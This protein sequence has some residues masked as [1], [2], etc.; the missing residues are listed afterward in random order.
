MFLRPSNFQPFNLST[1]QPLVLAAATFLAPINSRA[2]DAAPAAPVTAPAAL[3][4]R[5]FVKMI[6]KDSAGVIVIKDW[7]KL[8]KIDDRSPIGKLI[9]NPAIEH[10]ALGFLTKL[11]PSPADI[12]KATGLDEA[13]ALR[14]FKGKATFSFRIVD[15]EE[16][17]PVTAAVDDAGATAKIEVHPDLQPLMFL[18]FGGNPAEHEKIMKGLKQLAQDRGTL[19]DY[20]S[21][22][23]EGALMTTVTTKDKSGKEETFCEALVDG[24]IVIA[25]NKE[26]LR[27]G[28]KA[29]RAGV[30]SDNFA[31]TPEYLQA[32]AEMGSQDGYAIFN[33]EAVGLKL[34]GFIETTMREQVAKN[35]QA[36]MFLD[37]KT[38]MD[39]LNLENF[40]L[41]YG[42]FKL[43]EKR[44]VL[45][46]GLTWKDKVGLASLVQFGPSPVA[47]PDFVTTEFK[48]ASVSTMDISKTWDALRT[49][50]QKISPQ[51]WTMATGMMAATQPEL[52]PALEKIRDDLIL[53]LEPEVIDLT[54][55]PNRH[56]DDNTQP[57]KIMIFK[58]KNPDGVTKAINTA[59][60]LAGK[61]KAVPEPVKRDY[62]GST[63]F[64][65]KG[66]NSPL[67]VSVDIADG[68]EDADAIKDATAAKKPEKGEVS[69]AIVGDRFIVAVGEAGF[70]ETVIANI[71]TPGRPLSK[72]G[73]FDEISA[74]SGIPAD[75]SYSDLA[76]SLRAAINEQIKN[77]DMMAKFRSK[78]KPEGEADKDD[79]AD[80]DDPFAKMFSKEN[81]LKQR[82]ALKDM[83]FHYASKTFASETGI[84]MKALIVEDKE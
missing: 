40:R 14:L 12:E 8:V 31:S 20:A 44:A 26:L 10:S 45:N 35:P 53:N 81:L 6:A 54:G 78:N 16:K 48:G 84:H 83:H 71:K 56:P 37:P 50:L 74:V 64:T 75:L 65:Y 15:K 21:E 32:A 3:P 68:E 7:G 43:E 33:L 66:I 80:Q 77:A 46:W 19:F 27:D 13:A 61:N 62:L 52:M 47:M 70:I 69:Y 57:G 73:V 29:L 23:F 82:D 34:R 24:A 72:S 55:F 67:G 4:E 1:F 17:A 51:G 59:L 9:K 58:V 42:S 25:E 28:I 39:A 11:I 22:P 5:D 18:E 63:I 60:G 30:I 49:L 38:V 76:T 79:D 2:A 36:A 41:F